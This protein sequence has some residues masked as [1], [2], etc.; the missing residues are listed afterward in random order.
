MPRRSSLLKRILQ[1]L[2]GF[3]M[4]AMTTLS[5]RPHAEVK[6]VQDA[7]DDHKA[8]AATFA[9]QFTPQRSHYDIAIVGAGI[10]G[11]ATARELLL[12]KPGL[13]LIVV[14]KD[15]A[16]AS[17]Q[18]GH[19]SGVLHTGIYYA[20]GSLKAQACVE[21]HRRMIA[22][23]EENSIP[24]ELCG[25]LIVALDESELPR[26]EEL[27]RRGT[28]NGV[29]GL[30]MIGPER[31]R[32]IEPH[33]AGIKAIWSPN[34]GIV[35]YTRVAAAY[36]RN[37]QERGG[38]IVVGHEVTNIA[39]FGSSAILTTRRPSDGGAAGPEIDAAH[40]ITCAGLQSDKVS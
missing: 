15:A 26:L 4:I 33:A 18:S 27:Y 34:T 2:C 23:C 37:V 31:L 7:N 24:V 30:E 38:E 28:A 5:S 20:P 8:A 6:Q 10:V 19:N 13:R 9:P 22:F 39:Q 17:Q 36:A 12:R 35:D 16:I 14:E 40:V 32:E 3:G 25:K 21:G 1:N 29:T 11:L